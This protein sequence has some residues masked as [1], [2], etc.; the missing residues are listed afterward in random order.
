MLLVLLQGQKTYLKLLHKQVVLLLK[1]L[2]FYR[3]YAVKLFQKENILL[4]LMLKINLFVLVYLFAI[5]VAT[6]EVF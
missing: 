4:K 1:H 5:A 6:L 2:V 3:R